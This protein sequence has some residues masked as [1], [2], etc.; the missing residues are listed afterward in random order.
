MIKTQ[1]SFPLKFRKNNTYQLTYSSIVSFI[2]LFLAI[3]VLF[4]FTKINAQ[5]SDLEYG[6]LNIASGAVIGGIGAVINKE[7]NQN[8]H[9]V[10][11]K[12]LVQGALGGYLVFE[13]KRLLGIVV[14]KEDYAYV[15]PSKVIN[16]AGTSIIENAAANR[17]FWDRWHL[18]LGF[19][20][21][22]VYT[23]DRLHF[24]YRIMPFSLFRAIQLQILE[25]GIDLNES[26][27]LGV[28]VFSPNELKTVRPT[29]MEGAQSSNHIL[30]KNS[31]AGYE[32]K[33]HEIIHVYQ[34][35]QFS[36]FNS[37]LNKA[38]NYLK[39]NYKAY[40]LYQKIFYTDFNSPIF[41]GLYHLG[42]SNG[43]SYD[44]NIF[45][46]EAYFLTK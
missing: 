11:G 14:K 36:G 12:G 46:K 7:P 9:K 40:N 30:L 25:G 24:Q 26:L 41:R 29:Y 6:L 3:A 2:R 38:D 15:W 8:I 33:A 18:N 10:L 31:V 19:T 17:D 20:R 23:N 22:D 42:E 45:E 16:S 5:D 37:Y 35:N 4:S 28:L 44:E 39:R 32:I 1:I 34:N 21:L 13:S 27:K 43:G